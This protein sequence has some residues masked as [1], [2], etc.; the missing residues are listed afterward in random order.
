LVAGFAY[1]SGHSRLSM[2]RRLCIWF[3]SF[4]VAAALCVCFVPFST[5]L[6]VTDVKREKQV[7]CGCV[8]EGEEFVLSYQHSVNR[9][10]VFDTL[11]MGRG[12][13]VIVKSRFDSFGAGMPEKSEQGMTLGVDREGWIVWTVNRAVPEV[14]LFVGWVANHSLSFR[15]KT[16]A[17]SSLVEPGKSLSFRSSRFSLYQIWKGRCI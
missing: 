16:I 10:P 8:E 9:R 2:V 1:T 14:T 11:Q 13:L 5:V 7:L 17:L 3:I 4:G 6:V 12:Q 15:G